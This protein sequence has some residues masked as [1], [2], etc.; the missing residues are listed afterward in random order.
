M[1]RLPAAPAGASGHV[2]A[3]WQ[4]SRDHVAV[5]GRRAGFRVG[6]RI[7]V[8]AQSRRMGA[9]RIAELWRQAA[10]SVVFDRAGHRYCREGLR[11][12]GGQGVRLFR[13]GLELGVPGPAVRN[14]AHRH[15]SADAFPQDVL[16]LCAPQGCR[17][18]S[19]WR[20]ARWGSRWIRLGDPR[21]ARAG[22]HATHACSARLGR[23][24]VSADG[25]PPLARPRHVRT[26]SR[27]AARDAEGRP[28]S[29]VAAANSIST[30]FWLRTTRASPESPRS[31]TS[32]PRANGCRHNRWPRFATSA[33]GSRF[34]WRCRQ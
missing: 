7:P 15:L 24:R 26:V 10:V 34:R 5:A 1:A 12:A 18:R 33:I 32:S 21:A 16:H 20:R 22:A 4:L 31:S 14:A 30:A 6:M 11:R 27:H 29:R 23:I 3:T 17:R 28:R 13:S 8:R 2:P 9:G 25:R 19:R